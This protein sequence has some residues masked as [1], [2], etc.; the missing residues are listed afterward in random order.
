[1]ICPEPKPAL[2]HKRM[3]KTL[4]LSMLVLLTAIVPILQASPIQSGRAIQ[5]TIQ[6]VPPTEAA[7]I[8]GTYPVSDAGYVRLWSIGNIKA[9]GVD[10]ATLGQRI[11]AAYRAAEIYTSPTI[12]VLSDSSDR[13]VEQMLTVGGKVRAPGAKPWNSGMT[14]F[15]AVMAAGG[16]TEF[17]AMN[18]VKLYRNSR[19]YTYDLTKGEHKLLKVYANDTIDVPQKNWAGR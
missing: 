3:M 19:V 11:E 7:R 18:R 4:L 9:A 16:P 2:K 12:Q 10:S 8:N 17:G 15:D 13:L 1:M 14:L 5:I 6:G